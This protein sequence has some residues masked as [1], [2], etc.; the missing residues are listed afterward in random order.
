MPEHTVLFVDDDPNLL[1]SMVRTLRQQPYRLFTAHDGRE[2]VAVFKAH[3]VDVVV[4]DESM[5][6]LSGSDLLAWVAEHYPDVMRIVLTGY[7]TTALA[8]RA[9]N[10][11]RVFH[12]FTKPCNAVE[13][14]VT[15]RR[16]LEERDRIRKRTAAPT[17]QGP[18]REPSAGW[19]DFTDPYRPL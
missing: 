3:P 4:A 15:I 14:A 2:A 18:P 12:F 1:R 13:L 9:V 6:G 17:A 8:I 11:G 10:E 19:Y 5:P 7:P 16:A